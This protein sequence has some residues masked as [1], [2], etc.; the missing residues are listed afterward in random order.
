MS[1]GEARYVPAA[2]GRVLTRLYDTV[3][4]LTMR[5]RTFRGR[6]TEQV[7]DDL[8]AGA[9]VVDVGCGTGTFA[10]ALAGAVPRAEVIGIDGDPKI[11]ALA[12]RK[13]GAASVVWSEG[14]ATSLQ[15]ADENVDRVVMSLLLH[16]LP[17]AAKHQAV[18]EALR[19]LR[20]GGRLH[21]ADWGRPQGP[22]MRGV[23]L[24]TV[25]LVDGLEGTRDHAAELLARLVAFEGVVRR[26][27]RRTAW[28]TPELLTAAKPRPQS[29]AHACAHQRRG[30]D[31][32]RTP[33]P[34]ALLR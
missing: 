17:P 6:L 10:V 25:Q 2:G 34:V 21:V 19:V 14:L 5:E 9:R 16:H 24:V 11:L 8:P 12:Q 18:L 20:P 28:E 23:F 4:A 29:S 15:V 32:G 22:L 27:R 26:D 7:L 3:I 13:P 30:S 1:D 33:H 31:H